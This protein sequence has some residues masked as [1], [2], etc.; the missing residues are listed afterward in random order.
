MISSRSGGTGQPTPTPPPTTAKVVEA[1]LDIAAGTKLTAAMLHARRGPDRR[2][3][4]LTRSRTRAS[5]SASAC[6]ARSAPA[7]RSASRY[8]TETGA[9][10]S[11]TDNIPKGLRAMAIQV[12]QVTG[13]GTLIHTGD[14]VDVIVSLDVQL[15]GPDPANKANVINLGSARRHRSSSSSRTSR[16]S[17]PSCRPRSPT[18]RRPPRRRSRPARSP[19]RSRPGTNLTGQN[20][21]VIVAVTANQA[22]VIRWA[23]LGA[24]A[25]R[26]T[27]SRHHRHRGRPPLTQGLRRGRR[28]RQPGPRLERHPGDRRAAAREDRRRHPQDPHRQVRRPSARDPHQV[29]A[30]RPRSAPEVG[31]P[32]VGGGPALPPPPRRRASW[33][34]RSASSSSTT[35]RRPATTSRSFSASRAT[36]KWSAPP[37]PAPRL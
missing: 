30:G 34:T 36:S 20:E 3:H 22:E 5:P 27:G 4:Q 12:D 6:S 25:G 28:E 9:A 14:S 15:T 13:V 31:P 10:V 16:S 17:A 24:Q 26:R 23:Q 21:V 33:P 8:F 35:S 19:R 11:V 32:P 1:K 2:L 29:G 37:H 18:T 7:S